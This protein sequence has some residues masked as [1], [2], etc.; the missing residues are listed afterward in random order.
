MATKAV[1]AALSHVW[2][3]LKPTNCPRALM[4]GLSLPLW[5]HVRTTR[6]VDLLISLEGTSVE[7]VLEVLQLAGIRTRHDP[8]V[9]DLGSVR[10]IQLLYQPKDAFLNV[11][12][13]MLLAESAF[14]REA[15]AR[16]SLARL[17]DLNIDLYTL[18]CEDILILKMNAGRIIDRADG[19]A[20]LRESRHTRC[21]VPVEMGDSTWPGFRV[22][23]DLGRGVSGR[24]GTWYILIAVWFG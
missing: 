17:S 13:D 5:K 22:G 10:I 24:T 11:P 23:R 6:D 21:A 19:A 7:A 15:L 1:L 9:L 16:R 14:H 8:P 12:I 18:S 3:A 2:V 20:L 4:G